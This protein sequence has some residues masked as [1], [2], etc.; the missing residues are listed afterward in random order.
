[1]N[2]INGFLDILNFTTLFLITGGVFVGI[3]FGAIPGLSAFTALALFLP[4]TFGMDPINGISFLIAVYVGGLSGGLIS[5]ILLGIPG[6]PSSIATC[7]DGFPMTKRG[8]GGKA[9]GIAILFSF[10]GG[11]FGAIILTFL[12]PIIANFALKFGPYEYFAVILF[13]LTTVSGLSSGNIVKGLL[14]CLLGICFS[15]IGI[16]S[17]S[18][19][20][21]YTFGIKNLAAGL[22]LIPLLIGIFAVSQIIEEST[23]KTKGLEQ[24]K[25]SSTKGFGISLKEIVMQAK[26]FIPASIIGLVIGILPGIGGNAS[27]LM[28][29]T[30]CKKRSKTPEKF[31]KGIID[32]LI[33]SE[34]ANNA[35][36][37]G[38]LIILL[39]LG[40]P[41]DNATSM[42][43]AGFQIHG[44]TP[45]PLLFET[46]GELLYALFAAFIFSNVCMLV[47][48]KL[49][50]PIF[51]KILKVPTAF[52]LPVVIAF[53]YVGSF[54]ANNRTF[55]ITIMVIFGLIG[56]I[57]KYFKYPLAPLV[58]G[59]ILSPLLEENIR[60]SLMR[61]N[62]S[63]IPIFQSPIAVVFLIMTLIT[64]VLSVKN[65]LK[66]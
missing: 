50:L 22:N 3:I 45:G 17:L 55:D 19:Y 52:L 11:I 9:L 20:T 5:A 46:N 47:L 26:N 12:G 40:I 10:I 1:M 66:K 21:R 53:C 41:G 14:S 2:L 38:A 15:F 33:A 54:S 7:F 6:T 16:D 56:F 29:Y 8:E 60:R 32:G 37:G 51:T 28:A 44:L 35:T 36:I 59:F 58:V 65:E 61:T 42:I 57:L 39:T 18:S 49:G 31:G 64:I 4:I 13:A 25:V 23:K 62:G 27:N 34:T 43:L 24:P 48:E 30:Y 63:L